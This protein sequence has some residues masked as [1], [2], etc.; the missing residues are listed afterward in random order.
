MQIDWAV[1]CD[2]YE[3]R[4]DATADIYEAGHDTYYV[5]SVPAECD[6]TILVRLILE[7]GETGEI[8]LELVAPLTVPLGSKTYPI[9]AVPGTNHRA[10]YLVTQIEA[11]EVRFPVETEGIYV[12]EIR[13]QP[14]RGDPASPK[15]HRSVF[16]YVREG[17]VD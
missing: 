16:L 4:D 15:W 8:E 1:S 9:Q 17:T 2:S 14:R 3:L 10:G 6:L 13:T 12:A 5:G 7:E 11:L